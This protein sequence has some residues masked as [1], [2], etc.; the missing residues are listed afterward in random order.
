MKD[1]DSTEQT[2]EVEAPSPKPAAETQPAPAA[3]KLRGRKGLWFTLVLT[4]GVSLAAASAAG[5]LWWQQRQSEAAM[6][7]ADSAAA[8]SAVEIRS[9][10]ESLEEDVGTLQRSDAAQLEASGRFG[11]NVDELSIRFE[12]LQSRVD[13]YQGISGDARRRWLL[14]EAEHYLSLGNAELSLGGH[15]ETAI[16]ALELADDALRQLAEPAFAGVRQQ[17]SA[18]LQ[19]LRSADLA[20]VEGLSYT[21]GRLAA[22]VDELPMGPATPANLIAEP[23]G[24]ADVESGWNRVW[25]SIKGAISGMISV[26]RSGESESPALTARE[27]SLIRRQLELELEMARLGLLQNRTEVFRSGVETAVD[28]LSRHFDVS[29]QAVQSAVTLLEDMAQ[30]EI[31]PARPDISGSLSLLRELAARDG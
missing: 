18:D 15:W 19:T 13:D 7:Q 10:V 14:A 17:I 8:L 2:A 20:D 23:Q 25:L 29:E 16:V 5:L 27:Q 22:R 28:L 26:E 3:P 12:A 21:L 1:K 24:L 4:M 31:E 9:A 6:A 11:A 30:L